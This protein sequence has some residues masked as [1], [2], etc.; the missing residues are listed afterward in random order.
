MQVQQILRVAQNDKADKNL[1]ALRTGRGC[2]ITCPP[3]KL[4]KKIIITKTTN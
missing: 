4:E 3:A 2:A 1:T